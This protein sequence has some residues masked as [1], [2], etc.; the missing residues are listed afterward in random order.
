MHAFPASRARFPTSAVKSARVT[1]FVAAM[2]CAFPAMADEPMDD[3]PPPT[4][5]SLGIGALSRQKPYTGIDRENKA[6]PL[7]QFENEHLFIFGPV[8]GLKLPGFDISETQRLNLSIVAKYDGSGYESDDAPILRGMR[9]RKG[10]FWAGG[11]VEWN[12]ALVDVSAEWLA[13]ASGNSDGQRFGLTVEKTWHFGEHLMLTPRVGANWLDEKYVDY[14]YGVRSS[15]VRPGRPAY[16]GKSGASAEVGVR[17]IYMFDRRHSLFLDVEVSTLPTEIKDSPLVDSS[18]ENR[19][20]L[21][22]LYRF[23]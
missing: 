22:Y 5:W 8:I 6:I 10:G 11:K 14:Y 17:G 9:E 21:G 20:F 19:V 12:T 23:R 7:V 13:D 3:G 2:A 1:A 4:S 16:A 15:E 18:T